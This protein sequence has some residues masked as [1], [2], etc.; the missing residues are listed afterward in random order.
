MNALRYPVKIPKIYDPVQEPAIVDG[1]DIF[2]SPIIYPS[3]PFTPSSNQQGGDTQTG[4]DPITPAPTTII[5][6]P[7]PEQVDTTSD[8]NTTEEITPSPTT[9]KTP[10]V[11]P[12]AKK[13]EPTLLEKTHPTQA[14]LIKAVDKLFKRHQRRRHH[15]EVRRLL[16]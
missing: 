15:R 14:K 7:V 13:T 8:E 1:F 16:R 3:S 6:P 9:K 11:P 2:V 4:G 12:M 10:P 5:T